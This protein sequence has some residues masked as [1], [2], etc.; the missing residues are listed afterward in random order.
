MQQILLNILLPIIFIKIGLEGVEGIMFSAPIADFV[1]AV[2][3]LIVINGVFKNFEKK[4]R[5]IICK[6]FN[7]KKPLFMGK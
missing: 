7:L 2:I 5:Q 6:P 4:I 3:S 1:A